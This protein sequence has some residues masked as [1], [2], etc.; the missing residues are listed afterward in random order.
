MTDRK[1]VVAINGSPH[2]GMGNTGQL[3]GF[4]A[5]GLAA[6]GMDLDE[7]LL[8]RQHIEYCSGCA[9]CIGK[10]ACWIRDDYKALFKRLIEADAVILASPVYVFNVTGQMKTFLDRSLGHGHRPQASWKPGLAV[11][12]SAGKGELWAARYLADT[13][14]I[15]GAYSVGELTAIAV[16]PGEFYGLDA[17]RN[18]ARDLARDL[19]QAMRENRR[20]PPTEHDLAFW[21][22]IGAL[23]RENKAVMQADH[24]HWEKQ[25]LYDRFENYVGQERS[26]GNA[27]PEAMKAWLKE[28]MR[29]QQG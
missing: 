20:R 10:G 6:E 13:L 17:V 28:L 4:L 19:A 27:P 9:M 22:F 2:E 7:V 11:S 3:I 23:A 21:Q 24:E 1:K 29:R 26:P 25:G 18:R 15:F 16:G 5:E 8:C 12:V 14:R